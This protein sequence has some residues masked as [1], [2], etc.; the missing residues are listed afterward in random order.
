M[1][2]DLAVVGKVAG[3]LQSLEEV[4]RSLVVDNL[5]AYSSREADHSCLEYLAGN[6]PAAD[7]GRDMA[8]SGGSYPAAQHC[9]CTDSGTGLDL[10]SRVVEKDGQQGQEALRGPVVEAPV[11]GGTA[12]AADD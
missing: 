8:D 5:C 12:P 4:L 9:A 1:D 3:R 7:W 2:T 10:G 6:R 11:A